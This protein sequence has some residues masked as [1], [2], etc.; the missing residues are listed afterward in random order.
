VRPPVPS[1]PPEQ[2]DLA[3]RDRVALRALV[4]AYAIAL[5]RLDVE[6]FASLWTDDGVLTI[7]E[8]GPRAQPTAEIRGRDR[9]HLPFTRLRTYRATIHVVGTHLAEGAPDGAVGTTYCQAHH[10]VARDD[11][12]PV[13]KV[14]TI[15][16][17]D[18]FRSEPEGWRFSHRRVEVLLRAHQQ[19]EVL[20]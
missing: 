14:L 16:Y 18:S 7:H 20:G 11:G 6:G 15:R 8:D 12:P 10:L 13:D 2:R 19:P 1:L 4:D 9:M 17:R 5:D 3:A